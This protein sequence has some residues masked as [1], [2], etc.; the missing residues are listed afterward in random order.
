MLKEG[1]YNN[2]TY[3]LERVVIDTAADSGAAESA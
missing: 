2:N 3:R 1:K